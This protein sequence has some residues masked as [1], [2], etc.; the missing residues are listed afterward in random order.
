MATG[1]KQS[2]ARRSPQQTR[3]QW[4]MR[5]G[6][7]SIVVGVATL[8][9]YLSVAS[10]P[11]RRLKIAEVVGQTATST[12]LI[13][14]KTSASGAEVLSG[15]DLATQQ[16]V[17]LSLQE[18]ESLK[19]RLGE[20]S[21]LTVESNCLQL[22]EGQLLLASTSGCLGAAVIDSNNGVYTLERLGSLGEIKVLS[23]QVMVKI[24]SNPAIA[25]ITLQ[26]KQKITLSLAGEQVGPIRLM[27]PSE[28]EQIS[29][30][31]LFQAFQTPLTQAPTT[32]TNPTPSPAASPKPAPE[33]ATKPTVQPA[34]ATPIHPTPPMPEVAAAVDDSEAD[35]PSRATYRRRRVGTANSSSRRRWRPSYPTPYA[36]R[37][38]TPSHSAPVAPEPVD[39]A[40]SHPAP[41]PDSEL[42]GLPYVEEA[43][44]PPMD[45]PPV[46]PAPEVS[47]PPPVLVEPPMPD[48]PPMPEKNVD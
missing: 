30:G 9:M 12:V 48:M 27:L 34:P 14:G 2:I 38:R 25:S 16:G 15:Q 3:P 1:S 47:V 32:A 7:A 23:G 40:P 18:Q 28:V 37:R 10:Q 29:T 11:S 5:F 44:R 43:P 6:V 20:Q 36:Y 17:K 19:A 35:T 45:L 42:D 31:P 24:P 46:S 21:R 26:P 41:H 8:G 13:D 39:P 22:T 4:M 33:S